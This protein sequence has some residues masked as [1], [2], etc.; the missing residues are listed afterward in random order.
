MQL[1][2][3]FNGIGVSATPSLCFVCGA[4]KGDGDPGVCS[5]GRSIDWEG[6]VELCKNCVMEMAGLFGAVAPDKAEA[7]RTRNRQLGMQVQALLKGRDAVDVQLQA[8]RD[9]VEVLR[10]TLRK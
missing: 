6:A 3:D 4:P 9:E 5:V 7:L 1:I 2:G 10:E 8:L